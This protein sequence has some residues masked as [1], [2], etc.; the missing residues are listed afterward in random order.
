MAPLEADV[1]LY[2]AVAFKHVSDRPAVYVS[3]Q[4]VLC[5]SLLDGMLASEETSKP[6]AQALLDQLTKLA[7]RTKKVLAAADAA[8]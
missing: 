5:E 2:V 1:P 4:Q 6:Q 3:T 8:T 7:A